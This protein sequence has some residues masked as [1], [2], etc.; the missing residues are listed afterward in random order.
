LILVFRIIELFFIHANLKAMR[1]LRVIRPLRTIKASPTLRKTITA[2]IQSLPELAN[3]M[4][5]VFFVVIL[6]SI[7]GLQQYTGVMYH[8]CRETPK[9]LNSTYWPKSKLYTR[10][11]SPTLNSG[12]YH[13]PAGT[14]CGSPLQYGISLKDDGVYDD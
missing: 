10:I 2:L 9:P 7:L 12:D 14:F 3:A 1:I 4:L 13:C 11:C 8:R 6:F 5:F